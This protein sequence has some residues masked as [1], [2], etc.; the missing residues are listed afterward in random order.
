MNG[1]YLLDTNIIIALFAD[2]DAV[3][4]NLAK[5]GEVF[6]PTIAI[7]EL[8]YGAR[9]SGRMQENLARIEEF[10]ATNVVLECDSDTARRYGEIKNALRLKGRPIPENDIWISAIS[11]QHDLIVV[12]RDAHFKEIDSLKTAFW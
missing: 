6:V 11:F 5:A 8:C 7:G 10:V 12:T 9:K 4:Q 2:E 3:K 1:R